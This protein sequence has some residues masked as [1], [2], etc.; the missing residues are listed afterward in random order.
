R[1]YQLRATGTDQPGD[2]EDFPALEDE[3]HVIDPFAPGVV[4]VVAGDV[5]R[6]EDHLAD[7]MGFGGVK[8][9]H[10]P[11]HHLGDDLRDVH[12]RHG[13]RCDVLAVADHRNGV[14][15][16]RH[17]IELVGDINA[18]YA[19]GLEVADDVQQHLDFRAGEGG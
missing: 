7:V 19:L 12:V 10:F 14:A 4:D 11:S 9:A 5:A 18:S 3:G 2:T 13:S 15:N 1:R 8:V 16:G 17:F 6:L